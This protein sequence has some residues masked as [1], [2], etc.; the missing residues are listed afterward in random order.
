M[1][2]G[3]EANIYYD[4]SIFLKALQAGSN[5]E[6]RCSNM[7]EWWS[8]GKGVLCGSRDCL[9]FLHHVSSC[10]PVTVRVAMTGHV[11]LAT[12]MV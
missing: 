8:E 10:G 1:L 3:V 2:F 4:R 9:T 5:V 11:N 12:R 7:E 6:E